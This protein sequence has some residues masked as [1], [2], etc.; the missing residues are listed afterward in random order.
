MIPINET[1]LLLN[2]IILPISIG[3]DFLIGEYPDK[4]HPTN[5]IGKTANFLKTKLNTGSKKQR[6]VKGLILVIFTLLIFVTPVY[7]LSKILLKLHWILWLIAMVFILKSTIAIKSMKKHVTPIIKKLEN[8]KQEKAK[9]ETSKIVSRDTSKLTREETIS[10]TI[11]STSESITDGIISPLFY[12][13]I[14]GVPGAIAYRVINTLDSIIGYKQ[15][16]IKDLGLTAAKTDTIL[17]YIPARLTTIYIATSAWTLEDNCKKTIQTATQE[18]NKHPSPNSTW[19]MAA[20]AGALNIKLTKPNH[21]IL[22]KKGNPPK[23]NH[24]EKSI[25]LMNLTTILFGSTIMTIFVIISI[26]V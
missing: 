19:P 11:E 15:P 7:L 21:Y 23:I 22:N 8:G 18:K 16:E 2:L 4:I 25:E 9:K 12:F 3:L 14:L 6:K 1:T 17:N 10:A 5:W 24:I 20:A 13:A 26:M